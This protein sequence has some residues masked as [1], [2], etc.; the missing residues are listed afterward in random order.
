VKE[1]AAIVYADLDLV[2]D[3]DADVVAVVLLDEPTVG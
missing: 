3:M 2:V 1:V